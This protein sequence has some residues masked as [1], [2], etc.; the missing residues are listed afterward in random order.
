MQRTRV[1]GRAKLNGSAWQI[2]WRLLKY[3]MQKSHFALFIAFSSVIVSAGASVVGTLFI[4]RLIDDYITPLLKVAHPNFTPLFHM[5][6]LMGAI[7]LLGVIGTLLYSQLMIM[8]GQKLQK[9]IRDE[10][11]THMQELPLSYFDSNDYG[12]VMS[13]YTNDVDTLR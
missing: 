12:D 11:F 5:I 9:R 3:I 10:M 13:R 7:Y 1:A 8:T 6:I 4:Q 2:L